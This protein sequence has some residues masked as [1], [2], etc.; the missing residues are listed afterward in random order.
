MWLKHKNILINLDKVVSILKTK[1][2]TKYSL[3]LDYGGDDEQ[4]I[5]FESEEQ[6]DM[7]YSAIIHALGSEVCVIDA[8]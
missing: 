4:Y 8:E 1:T 5:N 7:V 2:I 6:R 3:W